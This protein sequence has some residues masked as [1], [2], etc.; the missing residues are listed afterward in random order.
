MSPVIRSNLH[1]SITDSPKNS[2]QPIASLSHRLTRIFV[3]ATNFSF[4]G[5]TTISWKIGFNEFSLTAVFLW[6]FSDGS[7]NNKKNWKDD[8]FLLHV[9]NCW[10]CNKK[11]KQYF[12]VY[13]FNQFSAKQL[14]F[15]FFHLLTWHSTLSFL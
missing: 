12:M 6:I 2:S 4:N 11:G 14:P 7:L 9:K 13:S 8:I 1:S 15:H 5:K 3:S 10:H